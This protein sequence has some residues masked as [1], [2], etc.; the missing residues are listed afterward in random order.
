MGRASYT[1]LTRTP[2]S[3]NTLNGYPPPLGVVPTSAAASDKEAEA[4]GCARAAGH[5][6]HRKRRWTRVGN[7]FE[8]GINNFNDKNATC[9]CNNKIHTSTSNVNN[10]RYNSLIKSYCKC[11]GR[12]RAYN[13]VRQPTFVVPCSCVTPYSCILCSRL[14]VKAPTQLVNIANMH[15]NRSNNNCHSINNQQLLQQITPKITFQNNV[16][17][18]QAAVHLQAHTPSPLKPPPVARTPPE[19]VSRGSGRV[20]GVSKSAWFPR[21]S[22]SCRGTANTDPRRVP[23]H[24]RIGAHDPAFHPVLSQLSGQ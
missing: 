18:P 11:G 20:T 14:P 17:T 9:T 3:S 16:K 24:E 13:T 5:R 8:R 7:V 6:W 10:N 15:T 19:P 23:L 12:A 2:P 22:N 4:A 21:V 1:C